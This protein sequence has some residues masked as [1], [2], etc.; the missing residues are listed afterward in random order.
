M[1]YL[2]NNYSE[3]FH[4]MFVL[5]VP[6]IEKVAR[7][8]IVYLVLILLIRLFGK[9]ELA[10]LNQFDL[11]VLLSLSNTVQ[12]AIIGEDNSVIGG[13]IGAVTLLGFNSLMVRLVYKHKRLEKLLEGERTF[14]IENG[15]LNK[16]ALS[17][18]LLT[19]YDLVI[20]AHRQGYRTLKE[21]KNCVLDPGGVIF[22]ESKEPSIQEMRHKQLLEKLDAIEKRLEAAA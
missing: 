20:A 21:I 7:P 6:I 1:V 5:G 12:N 4:N 19:V 22:F 3:L 17:K 11:V 8:I 16:E 15:K 2:L 14:L 10:Q 9:R 13:I 18:E